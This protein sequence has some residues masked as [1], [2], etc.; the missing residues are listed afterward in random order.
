MQ[1]F[2]KIKSE[3]YS[4]STGI[5]SSIPYQSNLISEKQIIDV[6]SFYLGL[7]LGIVC[8]FLCFSLFVDDTKEFI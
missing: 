3:I 2:G 5:L 6:V 1:H 8:V 4:F 7:L